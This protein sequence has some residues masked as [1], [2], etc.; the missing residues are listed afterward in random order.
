MLLYSHPAPSSPLPAPTLVPTHIFLPL[1]I[2]FHT[3]HSHLPFALSFLNFT[4]CQLYRKPLVSKN[5][6]TVLWFKIYWK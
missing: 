5:N 1:H 4:S 2:F 3:A 6:F